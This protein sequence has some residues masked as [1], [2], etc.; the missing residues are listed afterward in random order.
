VNK[1]R[2][3]S[4]RL[5]YDFNQISSSNYRKITD[6]VVKKFNLTPH[7]EF[8]Q[9]LDEKFQDFIFSKSIVSLEWDIW[10]GYIVTAKN[11]EAEELVGNISSYISDINT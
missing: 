6:C 8:T 11:S 10:L 1:S 4:N 2:D 7:S 3:S 9:S 5:T